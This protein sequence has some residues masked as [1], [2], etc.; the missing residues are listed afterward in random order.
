MQI[1]G[2]LQA[3][4]NRGWG[5]IPGSVPLTGDFWPCRSLKPSWSQEDVGLSFTLLTGLQGPPSFG[6]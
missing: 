4:L 3:L 1:T 2:P 5:I 6:A